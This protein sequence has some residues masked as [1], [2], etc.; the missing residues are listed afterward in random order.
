M[1]RRLVML[2]AVLL[3]FGCA[4]APKPAPRATL[5]IAC[6]VPD[7]SVFVDDQFVGTAAAWAK[8]AAFPAG[9]RRIE[10]RH[11]AHFSFFAEVTPKEGQRIDLEARLRPQLD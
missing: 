4:T 5:R 8:G 1:K 2:S 6:N 11:P 10:V 9:F 7:A 3:G